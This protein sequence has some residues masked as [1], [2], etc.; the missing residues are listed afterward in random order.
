[1]IRLL[2]SVVVLLGAVNAGLAQ[3]EP[4][5][6]LRYDGKPFSYWETY[7]RT[8]LKPERRIDALRAMAAFGS[9]GYAK[10]ATAVIVEMLK[11]YDNDADA[12]ADAEPQKATPDQRI[13]NE[14]IWRWVKSA[15]TGRW[16]CS[17]TPSTGGS[18]SCRQG[19]FPSM[20][21][22]RAVDFIAGW[23]A[24]IQ[25]C[26]RS[27]LG[28]HDAWQRKRR[29]TIRQEIGRLWR[30]HCRSDRQGKEG[31]VDRRCPHACAGIRGRSCYFSLSCSASWVRGPNRRCRRWCERNCICGTSVRSL[32]RSA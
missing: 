28:N 17:L 10:E 21:H 4:G 1:M 30:S 6:E 18:P 25:G 24:S 3:A 15:R 12:F 23:L 27:R 19:L 16:S 31:P 29:R 14:A 11:D 7:P 8:E 20:S 2:M 13:I 5:D 32:R 26:S 22:H 9:R